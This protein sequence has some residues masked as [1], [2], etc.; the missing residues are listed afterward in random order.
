MI[1]MIVVLPILKD[2]PIEVWCQTSPKILSLCI[3]GPVMLLYL[4]PTSTPIS[5]NTYSDTALVLGAA[6]GALIGL[7]FS[8]DNETLMSEFL[9]KCQQMSTL[10]R[11]MVCITRFAIGTI[12]LAITRIISKSCIT[13]GLSKML[14]SYRTA[15][16]LNYKRHVEV[17][18]KLITYALV[19]VNA[20]YL[21][22]KIF[23]YAGFS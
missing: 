9:L 7:G 4:Y 16:P 10:K 20:I 22:P 8:A 13:S 2:L 15:K 14:P 18:H 12:I 1:I 17:P 19:S 11:I 23:K 21:A 3:V 5:Y 6:S